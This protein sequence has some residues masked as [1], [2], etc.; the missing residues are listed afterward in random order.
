MGTQD[1]QRVRRR[2]LPWMVFVVMA[3]GSVGGAVLLHRFVADQEHRLLTE[4]ASEA[5][6]LVGSMFDSQ[7][8]TL[9]LLGAL[10]ESAPGNEAAVLSRLVPDGAPASVGMVSRSGDGDVVDAAVGGDLVA[11]DVLSGDRA[12]VVDRAFASDGVVSTVFA[13]RGRRMLM[14]A[15]VTPG[16]G[17]TGRVLLQVFAFQPEMLESA[18]RGGPF[19]ELD[20]AVYAS[21]VPD[22]SRVLF[23]T[24]A[25]PITGRTVQRSVTVAGD[26]W[27]LV[28]RARHPLVGGLA[29]DAGWYLLA[30]GLITAALMTGLLEVLNRR[31]AYALRLVDERTRELSEALDAKD[32][33]AAGQRAARE[34][35]EAANLSKSE[36]LSRMSHELRTP[37]NAV[38]GFA[39]LLDGEDLSEPDRDAVRQILKGGRHLL[40]LINEV[41]DITRIE[42]G[43][44][45]LSPEPVLVSDVVSDVMDLTRPL[46]AQSNIELRTDSSMPCTSYVLADRQRLSQ[47]LLNLV[48]NAIKYNR[49]GGTVTMSCEHVEPARLRIN[50]HDTG[51]GIPAEDHGLLFTPF[52]R[53]GAART[54]IEGTGIGLALSRRLAEAMGG[55]V[56]FETTLGEGTTFWVELPIVENP[57]D[58]YARLNDTTG[59]ATPAP[60]DGQRRT[61]LYVE[62][63]LANLRL[64]ERILDYDPA[65]T[66]MPAGQGR[67]GLDL[68]R[69]H[70]PDLILLDL[71]LP[72]VGG[73][74][75]LRR[76]RDDPV[77]ASIPVVIVSADATA[78]QVRRLLA[79]GA[80]AYITKPLDVA[81]LRSLVENL[82]VGSR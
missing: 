5:S 37:L 2:A 46:A 29:A 64:V 43:N 79:E 74:E 45:Q 36:F 35:A 22:E 17:G 12:A 1:N 27:S 41:L 76:L 73:D 30:A 75:V 55:T 77:T 62:D 51:P 40:E 14:F 4:R 80:H 48:S 25:T 20:G 69:Q 56:D 71:H 50:V 72:D 19:S 6:L 52:E 70:Q 60:T 15:T 68:A 18:G 34:A 65:I 7:T 53:L 26:E 8:A 67:L 61:I 66:L 32:E 23:A 57:V 24:A 44:F 42:T 28:V 81:E 3:A 47:V 31:R 11:G 54:T 58:R 21:K 33:L 16:G 39:Q 59:N 9:P 78:G 38:L 10:V 13:D 63:N 49:V 82:P